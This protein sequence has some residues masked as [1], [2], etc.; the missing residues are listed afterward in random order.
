MKSKYKIIYSVMKRFGKDE[1]WFKLNH[2]KEYKVYL[3]YKKWIKKNDK[4]LSK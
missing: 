2:P 4:N 3:R 1:A